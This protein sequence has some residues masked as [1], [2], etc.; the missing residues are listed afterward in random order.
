MFAVINLMRPII[1]VSLIAGLSVFDLAAVAATVSTL[2]KASLESRLANVGFLDFKTLLYSPDTGDN[3]AGVS[4]Q[5]KFI[6]PEMFKNAVLSP[7][8]L[9]K[10][11]SSGSPLLPDNPV[12][13]WDEKDLDILYM[14]NGDKPSAA[15]AGLIEAILSDIRDSILNHGISSSP[16]Q[17]AGAGTAAYLNSETQKVID[18][19]MDLEGSA[20]TKRTGFW[21]LSDAPGSAKILNPVP[22]VAFGLG[23]LLIGLIRRWSNRVQPRPMRL[24]DPA[25][26]FETIR[27]SPIRYSAG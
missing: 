26:C 22:I 1:A 4:N 13:G 17:A 21:P 25:T 19:I 5:I 8:V 6:G 18:Q 27:N 2:E 10:F 24:A 16:D 20:E 7:R 3:L 15:S 14:G 12:W 23:L 11:K 9:R